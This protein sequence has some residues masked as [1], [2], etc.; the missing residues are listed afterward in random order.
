MY[1]RLKYINK[2]E[3]IIK[4]IIMLIENM[5]KELLVRNLVYLLLN[6]LSFIW[7]DKFRIN[8]FKC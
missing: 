2:L 8:I 4:N 6:F 7:S 1:V 5:V 3:K